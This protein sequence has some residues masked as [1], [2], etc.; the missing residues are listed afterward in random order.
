VEGEGGIEA[1]VC[2]LDTSRDRAEVRAQAPQRPLLHELITSLSND[3]HYDARNVR[4]LLQLLVPPEMG[5][6]PSDGGG[7]ADQLPIQA[8]I[9][10]L[11]QRQ[12]RDPVDDERDRV[13]SENDPSAAFETSRRNHNRAMMWPRSR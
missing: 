8:G 9:C 1:V 5:A 13:V 7:G 2:T 4:T 6:Y 11:W 12:P 10:S 3:G